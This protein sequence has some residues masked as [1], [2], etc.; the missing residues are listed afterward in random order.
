MGWRSDLYARTV[1]IT[2][3]KLEAISGITMPLAFLIV[4]NRHQR[5]LNTHKVSKDC[6]VQT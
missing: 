2:N 3:N 4:I 1:S 5:P 6:L